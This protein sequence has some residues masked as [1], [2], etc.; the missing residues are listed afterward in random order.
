MNSNHSFQDKENR[1]PNRFRVQEASMES[2]CKQYVLDG[3][4]LK[5]KSILYTEKK[6]QHIER[7]E[8]VET[9]EEKEE[10]LVN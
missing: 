7:P 9:K 10:S 5:T 1:H 6:Y 3:D 8:K 4:R 2:I